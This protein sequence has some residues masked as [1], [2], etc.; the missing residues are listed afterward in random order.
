MRR[1]LRQSQFGLLGQSLFGLLCSQHVV[2]IV[3]STAV[4]ADSGEIKNIQVINELP[5]GDERRCDYSISPRFLAGATLGSA[6]TV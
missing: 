5:A 6:A 1:L 4:F 2:G 3:K